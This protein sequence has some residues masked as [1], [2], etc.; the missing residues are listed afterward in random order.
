[1]QFTDCQRTDKS[2]SDRTDR[3]VTLTDCIS[4]SILD[5]PQNFS[6]STTTTPNFRQQFGPECRSSRE[7]LGTKLV[8]IQNGGRLRQRVAFIFTDLEGLLCDY[9]RNKSTN[10]VAVN[11]CLPSSVCV[12]ACTFKLLHRI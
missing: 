6:R 8:F 3:N 4:A 5:N 9:D 7:S 12:G 1:M 2:L 10:D 11:T